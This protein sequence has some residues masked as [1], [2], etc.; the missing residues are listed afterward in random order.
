MISRGF[1][2]RCARCAGFNGQGWS[3]DAVWSSFFIDV[4]RRSVEPGLG[5]RES[6][7]KTQLFRARGLLR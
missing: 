7:L 1:S 5:L 3:G 4:R 6:S 2:G